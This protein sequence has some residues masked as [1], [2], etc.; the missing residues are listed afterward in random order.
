LQGITPAQWLNFYGHRKLGA[1]LTPEQATELWQ[2]VISKKV[3]GRNPEKGEEAFARIFYRPDA[4]GGGKP[5]L[6]LGETGT[7]KTVVAHM[8]HRHLSQHRPSEKAYT[9]PLTQI[10]CAGLGDLLESELFGA[11]AGAYTSADI[12]NPGKI[13]ASYGG[14]LFLDE[15]GTMSPRAQAK[16]LTYL[17][18]GEVTPQGWAAPPLRVP[19]QIVAATNADLL[20]EVQRGNFRADLYYRFEQRLYIPPLRERGEPDLQLLIQ[21]LLADPA[22]NPTRQGWRVQG[23]SQEALKKLLQHDYPGN[24]RELQSVLREGVKSATRLRDQYLHAQD[25]AFEKTPLPL[26]HSVVGIIKK[27]EDGQDWFLLR[28]NP[29]WLQYFLI[30]GRFEASSHTFEHA[31]AQELSTKLGLAADCYTLRPVETARE[32]TLIQYSDRDKQLKHY[33]FHLY[34]VKL[35]ADPWSPEDLQDR[36]LLWA[37]LAH[38]TQERG[39]GGERISR[40]TRDIVARAG[41]FADHARCPASFSR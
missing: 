19:V 31:L 41:V 30:G 37:T 14:V 12:T 8:I 2:N 7:G 24:Y 17:D 40:T 27:R 38:I 35:T 4:T 15:I 16:L 21:H 25:I 5:I 10:N 36:G 18:R 29:Y 11:M 28:F 6:L 3:S 34:S 22:I 33:A 32:V 23:V 39:P 9:P 20:D 13:V 26:Q 1:F